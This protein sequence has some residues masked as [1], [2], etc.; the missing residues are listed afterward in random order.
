MP[1]GLA[2]GPAGKKLGDLANVVI[3]NQ[4]P[5]GDALVPLP[6]GLRTGSGSTV[7]GAFILNAVLAET[8]TRLVALGI[9]PPVYIS[10][11][12]PDAEAHNERLVARYRAR[13]PHL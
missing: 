3:D 5:R 4:G 12:M 10:S 7:T 11:N 9:D 6:N 8:V 13:N 2:P 1:H